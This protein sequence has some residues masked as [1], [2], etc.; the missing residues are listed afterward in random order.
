MY[1]NGSL[2]SPVDTRESGD[3]GKGVGTWGVETWGVETWGGKTTVG[4][5]IIGNGEEKDLTTSR[6]GDKKGGWEG[7]RG[8]GRGD[9][10]KAAMARPG[11]PPMTRP[12]R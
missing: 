4:K 8:D 10:R 2:S 7:G 11:A 3:G 6:Y 9:V 5:I 12:L 1:R